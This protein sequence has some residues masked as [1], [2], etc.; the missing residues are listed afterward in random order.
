MR[1]DAVGRPLITMQPLG[2]GEA[3]CVQVRTFGPMGGDNFDFVPA[4][5]Q[6]GAAVLL[7]R[8]QADNA[9][10]LAEAE[11][12]AALMIL[13]DPTIKATREVT[14]EQPNEVG[15]V[16]LASNEPTPGPAGV[17]QHVDRSCRDQHAAPHDASRGLWDTAVERATARFRH[18]DTPPISRLWARTIAAYINRLESAVST[19]VRP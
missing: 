8:I 2:G 10:L 13:T 14:A 4:G 17:E 5:D 19:R 1:L 12:V 18:K 11:R 3:L 16:A 7:E 9:A 6:A 15:A